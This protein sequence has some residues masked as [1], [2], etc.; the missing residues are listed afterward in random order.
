MGRRG[1]HRAAPVL[2]LVC[3]VVAEKEGIARMLASWLRFGRST[4]DPEMLRRAFH[5]AAHRLNSTSDAIG[6]RRDLSVPL[7][8]PAAAIDISVRAITERD[9]PIIFDSS[10][11][12]LS[13]DE[14][15]LRAARRR[16]FDAGFGTCF[17]A[18][19]S[20]DQPC[21]TQWLF[22]SRDNDKIRHYFGGVFPKLAEDEA[23]LESAFTPE[24]FRGKR[25]MPAAMARIAEKAADIGARSVI[26]FVGVDNIPSLKGCARAGFLPYA[27]CSQ[28]WRLFRCRTAFKP[29]DGAATGPEAI[30]Q[31]GKTY[32]SATIR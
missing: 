6:L 3:R 12:G 27:R 22:G 20:D 24:A 11:H 10:A 28:N 5:A 16:L 15:W 19:T 7:E 18:V 32:T 23:L 13:G 9:V 14:K 31:Q 26:T 29:N 25:I 30:E 4:L 17:V 1:L 8:A 21:Y 2:V